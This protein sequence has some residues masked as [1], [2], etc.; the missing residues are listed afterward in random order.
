LFSG[1]WLV[2]PRQPGEERA[3]AAGRGLAILVRGLLVVWRK[4]RER[5][6]TDGGRL[7]KGYLRSD[8]RRGSLFFCVPGTRTDGHDFAVDAAARGAG[9]IVVERWI[10]DLDPAVSQVRVPSVRRAMGPISADVFGRPAEAM[11]MVGVTGTNGKTTTTWI[12]R[13]LLA[14]RWPTASLGTLGLITKDL[15][16]SGDASLTTPGPV[17][18]ARTF[19]RLNDEG[20]RA[21]VGE[22]SSH[23][24]DQGRVHALRFD[25]AVFL[26]LSRDHLDYHASADA[27][28]AAKRSLIGYLR[29]SGI[30][31]INEDD[32]AWHGLSELAPKAL[33]FGVSS[34]ADVTAREIEV[35]PFGVHFR[36]V[37]SRGEAPVALPLLGGY[38]V[39]NALAAA[40]ACLGL[41]FEPQEIADGLASVAQVPGRLERVDGADFPILIDYA[42]TPEALER[43][44]STLRPL[45]SGRLIVVFGAG[46]DRDRGKRPLMGKVA[47]QWA[48]VAVVTSDN[49]RTEDPAAIIEEIVAGAP[50]APFHRRVDRREGI[51]LGL[52]LA[53]AGDVV[54]LAGKGHE[55]YQVLGTERVSFDE[56]QIV[57]DL[58]AGRTREV[59]D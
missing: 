37:T 59:A 53:N 14:T 24:L 43:V 8:V 46:G 41:G 7:V 2:G 57:R 22:I 34:T 6:S 51:E 20:V 21:V 42:H 38:N 12:L 33:S 23:A 36:L 40:T 47:A 44:L 28:R 50:D 1:R 15:G 18:M 49:P 35:G 54:L 48:D 13:H 55:T 16:P 56:R 17:E 25:A 52:R 4:G 11:V 27:Y 10:D 30:G 58:L 19:R 3:G 31:V 9:A 32:P 29:S 39:Q 26:N 5:R 45:V